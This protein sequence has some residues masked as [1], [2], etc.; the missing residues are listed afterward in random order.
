MQTK[1]NL[2]DE[3]IELINSKIG[4]YA[5]LKNESI[6]LPK[7]MEDIDYNVSLKEQQEE[8]IKL[9]NWVIQENKKVVILFEG[10]DAAGKG[11]AIR[12]ITEHINPRHFKIIALNIPTSDERKQWFFQRYINELPKPGEIVFFDR[13]W[14]NR[15][16]V[17]PVNGFC[18]DHEYK[19]F[20]SQVNNFEAMLVES[21]TYLIKLYFSISKSE[22]AKR[23]KDIKNSPLKRW[24]MTSVDERAQELWDEYTAYKTKMFAETNTETAPWTIIDANKKST[25]RLE[26]ISHIL[27]SIPYQ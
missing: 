8:L 17:E 25:A 23:F 4:L 5:L 22:Q 1:M 11:G 24:K 16:V 18:S 3:Q 7:V 27:K 10:R 2:T 6:D 21:D 19:V 26:A 20:M 15:A 14:Y 9:Q 13:S 12:R